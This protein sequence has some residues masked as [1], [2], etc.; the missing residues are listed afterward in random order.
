VIMRARRL[1]RESVLA[2]TAT[3][4]WL[5]GCGDLK[6]KATPDGG[7][8]LANDARAD[9]VSIVFI[10]MDA[11]TDGA[12]TAGATRDA[13]T[14][15]VAALDGNLA[16]I[17]GAGFAG[18]GTDAGLW[19]VTDWRCAAD[20]ETYVEV[21]GD[22]DPIRLGFPLDPTCGICDGTHCELSGTGR[23]CCGGWGDLSFAACAEPGGTGPC[24]DARC[25]LYLDRDGKA[26]TAN[27]Q[28][29]SASAY[30][31]NGI[32]GISGTVVLSDGTETRTLSIVIQICLLL[33]G[34]CGIIC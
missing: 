25:G 4:C 15:S 14:T 6:P 30:S 21:T 23:E 28:R 13:S 22:G 3:L 7:A 1:C 31:R 10:G 12:D 9:G 26:W 34:G 19:W 27:L 32:Y 18:C 33:I 8:P 17:D 5:P 20:A 24:L 29:L 16:A 11:R 2:L